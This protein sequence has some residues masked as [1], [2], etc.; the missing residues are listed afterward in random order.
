M[1][2]LERYLAAVAHNL[3]EAVQGDV[4]RELRGN[5][6]DQ[7]DARR[8]QAP[9]ASDEALLREVLAELGPPRVMAQRF[10]QPP[11]L[12]LPQHLP[13]YRYTLFMVFGVLFLIQIV[14]SSMIWLASEHMGL[15]L[16]MKSIAGGFIRDACF[17]FSV[18]SLA[19]WLMGREEAPVDGE[20]APRWNPESLPPLTRDWQR[21]GFSDIYQELATY[22]FL[23][24]L[25][26]YPVWAGLPTA[27]PL[28]ETSRTLLQLFS[29]LLVLG[30]GLGIWQ[31]FRRVWT[32]ALLKSSVALNALLVIAILALA[33]SGPV[34]SAVPASL[35]WMPH[36]RLTQSITISLLILAA[37]PAWAALR[38]IRRLRL[39][40]G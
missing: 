1:E 11:P 25:I 22:L 39:L 8:E 9:A 18:I 36:E 15:L 29:P 24:M 19:F 33:F 28:T 20:P 5:I 13:I 26:W 14:H 34:F 4:S 10:H 16:L 27:M 30:L 6:L 32:P 40:A 3:P 35:S 37:F 31:L 38:D 2:L 23:L 17:A 7:L 12:I 21:I